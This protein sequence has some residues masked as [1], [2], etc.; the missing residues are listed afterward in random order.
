MGLL[1][2]LTGKDYDTTGGEYDP[3]SPMG[4]MSWM[5]L[6]A[7]RIQQGQNMAAQMAIAPYEHQAYARDE[8]GGPL[9]SAIYGGILEP[10][11]QAV[12][13]LP[14]SERVLN[15]INGGGDGLPQTPA[16]VAELVGGVKGGF[17]GLLAGW[18]KAR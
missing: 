5:D 10:G 9:Q 4:R 13:L 17:Q 1:N 8:A 2:A 12:K 3:N 14:G 16:S 18:P 15:Y 7:L 11:Y 6:N